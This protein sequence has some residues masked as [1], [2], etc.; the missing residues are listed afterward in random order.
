MGDV[1]LHAG[2]SVFIPGF[3]PARGVTGVR[4]GGLYKDLS[5]Q[6]DLQQTLRLGLLGWSALCLR[7]VRVPPSALL[8][9]GVLRVWSHRL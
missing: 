3:F 5:S 9:W 8:A 1:K 2:S 6:F 7:A 4:P